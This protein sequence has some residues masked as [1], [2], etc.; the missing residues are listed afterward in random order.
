MNKEVLSLETAEKL[1]KYEKT[2][3]FLKNKIEKLEKSITKTPEYMAA[4]FLKKEK[5]KYEE[6]L[7]MLEVRN[8]RKN[9]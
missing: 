9:H 2:I 1:A 3:E 7:I 8:E 5:A 6:V 4:T